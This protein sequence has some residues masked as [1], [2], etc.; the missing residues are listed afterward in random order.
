MGKKSRAKTERAERIF[1]IGTKYVWLKTDRAWFSLSV[2]VQSEMADGLQRVS[3]IRKAI[4]SD[5]LIANMPPVEVV[6]EIWYSDL[7]SRSVLID[8]AVGVLRAHDG[9]H[10]GVRIPAHVALCDDETFVRRVLVHE[11]LHCFQYL[12]RTIEQKSAH[13]SDSSIAL[14]GARNP[15]DQH[16]DDSMLANP[17]D[18]FGSDDSNS[19]IRHGSDPAFFEGASRAAVKYARYFRPCTPDMSAAFAGQIL[20]EETAMKRAEEIVESRRSY[21]KRSVEG[22][23]DGH[24]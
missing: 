5:S 18:W 6:P 24:L 21:S 20:L 10:F 17:S 8:G 1:A 19:L 2:V 7:N 22:Q 4:A 11:F 3:R 15:F 16:E 13:S 12:E 9:F 14:Q 23:V